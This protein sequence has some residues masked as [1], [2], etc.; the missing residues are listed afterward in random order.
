MTPEYGAATQL[1]KIDMLDYADL[2]AL[3]KF[4]HP[5]GKDALRDARKQ[6]RRNHNLFHEPADEDLPVIPT[7][8]SQFNDPGVNFLYHKLNDNFNE[9]KGAGW[10]ITI[11]R[12]TMRQIETSKR[13]GIIPS[14]RIQ[15]LGEIAKKLSAS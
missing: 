4:E 7:I 3:N 5:G 9:K 13:A 15:Y 6:Y 11:D 1:E 2:I 14:E 12:P 8:A 10:T